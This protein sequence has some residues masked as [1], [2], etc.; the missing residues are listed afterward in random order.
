MGLAQLHLFLLPV[1]YR[2]GAPS[3]RL[4]FGISVGFVPFLWLGVIKRGV[5]LIK[6][7]AVCT[8]SFFQAEGQ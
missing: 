6:L 8:P 1:N 7:T 2:F 4:Y 3:T 5:S